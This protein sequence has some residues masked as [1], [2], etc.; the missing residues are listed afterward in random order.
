MPAL[1]NRLVIRT[2]TK[3]GVLTIGV[4]TGAR[5]LSGPEQTTSGKKITLRPNHRLQALKLIVN[6]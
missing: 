6:V 1:V 5:S 4:L 2:A 3:T